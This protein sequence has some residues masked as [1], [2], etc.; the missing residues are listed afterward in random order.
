MRASPRLG[1]LPR[2]A[3]RV[4]DRGSRASISVRRRPLLL[5]R[6]NDER[7]ASCSEGKRMS[8]RLPVVYTFAALALWAIFLK[9]AA[10]PAHGVNQR[11]R[12]R[13]RPP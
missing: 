9:G 6:R 12:A 2:R 1:A 7:A 5:S 3:E 8:I 11:K 4:I 13:L 10:Q